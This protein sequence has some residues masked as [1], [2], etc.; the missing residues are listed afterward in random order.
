MKCITG[1]LLGDGNP[2]LGCECS[3][4]PRDRE[5]V[6]RGKTFG[7]PQEVKPSCWVEPV[8]Q[9][10]GCVSDVIGQVSSA[11]ILVAQQLRVS[12]GFESF[13]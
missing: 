6:S 11:G 5:E 4:I 2:E 13:Y 3:V 8:G 10:V 9:V 12:V 1:A 7:E